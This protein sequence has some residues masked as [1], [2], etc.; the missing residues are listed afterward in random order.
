M[1]EDLK[2]LFEERLGRFHAAMALEPHD[3]I[4]IATGAN[5]FAEVYSGNTKQETIYD[6]EKWLQAEIAFCRDFPEVDA[7]RTNRICGPPPPPPPPPFRCPG[8]EDL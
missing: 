2:E 6:P 3:R 5:Y 8:C 7:L 4:P 1:A